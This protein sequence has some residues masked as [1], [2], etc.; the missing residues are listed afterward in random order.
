MNPQ[1]NLFVITGPSGSG[2]DEVI[3]ILRG[4][5]IQFRMATTA[6][7]REPRPGER[8]GVNHYFLTRAEFER[9]ESEGKLLESAEVYGRR[10][11]TPRQEVDGPISSGEDV[12][13]RIDVQ[14]ARSV[15]EKLPEAVLIFIA[16]PSVEEMRRRLESRATEDK[17]ELDDRLDSLTWEMAFSEEC[18]YVVVNETG[19]QTQAARELGEIIGR[20]RRSRRENGTSSVEG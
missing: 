16:P 18:D 4:I 3:S 19:R 9:W 10:Y 2:K 11:G 6:V 12:V 14:G 13:L 8:H 15:K 7:T 20:V 17:T 1:G 5:G